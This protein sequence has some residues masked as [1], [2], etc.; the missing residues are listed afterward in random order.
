MTPEN[1]ITVH[2]GDDAP[3]SDNLRAALDNLI[4]ALED[5]GMAE[6]ADVE[7]FAQLGFTQISVGSARSGGTIARKPD[8]FGCIGFEMN[9]D[10]EQSCWIQWG[11]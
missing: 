3:I 1:S 2:I 5:S 4:R 11:G 10:D 8:E 6:S 9:D 7:G